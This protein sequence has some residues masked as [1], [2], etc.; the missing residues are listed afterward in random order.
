MACVQCIKDSIHRRTL[1]VCP[2]QDVQLV[3]DKYAKDTG[4]PKQAM[5]RK[6]YISGFGL[7]R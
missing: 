2:R 4:Q 7:Q 6:V 3:M 1:Q 5:T